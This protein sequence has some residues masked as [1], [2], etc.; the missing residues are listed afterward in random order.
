M[1]AQLQRDMVKIENDRSY[2][3]N[4]YDAQ[5]TAN[6]LDIK[7]AQASLRYAEE[8]LKLLKA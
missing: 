6:E 2:T 8:S 1:I 7:N 3:E 5:I 4:T